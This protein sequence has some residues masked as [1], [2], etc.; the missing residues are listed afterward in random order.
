M[1]MSMSRWT[2]RAQ[3]GERQRY[4]CICIYS[5]RARVVLG[6]QMMQLVDYWLPG[7]LSTLDSQRRDIASVAGIHQLPATS[8]QPPATTSRQQTVAGIH[9]RRLENRKVFGTFQPF[10]ARF[11]LESPEQSVTIILLKTNVAVSAKWNML[12][13]ANIRLVAW[14]PMAAIAVFGLCPKSA[15]GHESTERQ[16]GP[17]PAIL[18]LP[19]RLK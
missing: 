3:L 7:K 10:T 18:G 4:V 9:M 13:V 5:C 8:H 19:K 15:S 2:K 12:P 16:R 17:V 11:R 6:R 14:L 1:S